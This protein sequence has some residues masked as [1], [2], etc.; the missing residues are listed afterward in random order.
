M[1]GEGG[2]GIKLLL[3]LNVF[4]SLAEKLL[5]DWLL[6]IWGTSGDIFFYLNLFSNRATWFNMLLLNPCR[7]DYKLRKHLETPAW[8]INW[9]NDPMLRHPTQL[10]K[11][12]TW[13]K[14]QHV[15]KTMLPDY[16]I[17]YVVETEDSILARPVMYTKINLHPT[18]LPSRYKIARFNDKVIQWVNILRIYPDKKKDL[19]K[20]W[21]GW[22]EN[23]ICW[24]HRRLRRTDFLALVPLLS[25]LF[26][27]PPGNDQRRWRLGEWGG[28]SKGGF[29]PC[30]WISIPVRMLPLEHCSSWLALFCS[31]H[32][33]DSHDHSVFFAAQDI[34]R[35]GRQFI[36]SPHL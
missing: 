31:D 10:A 17:V 23:I 8:M 20:H 28:V 13:Q 32:A 12:K 18:F 27:S 26:I 29:E 9:S 36:H 4:L 22:K 21:R 3:D 11:P 6:T 34:S 7:Y 24:S 16:Q 30:S 35:K 14:E 5:L 25:F 2:R 1:K 15:A 33:S 19:I